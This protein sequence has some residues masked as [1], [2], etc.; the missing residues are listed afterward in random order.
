MFRVFDF[1]ANIF[2]VVNTIYPVLDLFDYVHWNPLLII[3]G[4]EKF[5]AKAELSL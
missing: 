1:A 5:E 4:L 2:F 3:Y